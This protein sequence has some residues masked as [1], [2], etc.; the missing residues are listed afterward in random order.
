MLASDANLLLLVLVAASAVT[1]IAGGYANR[2]VVVYVFKPLTM[3][4]VLVLAVQTGEGVPPLYGGLVL[5]GLLFSLA[6]DVLL[7]LPSDRF[8]AGLASFLV[9]HLLY[10]AA[11]ASDGA[12]AG[13]L[14]VLLPYAALGALAYAWLRPGLGRLGL[15]VAGYVAAIAAMTGLATARWLGAPSA[16]SAL[17]CAGAV[18]FLVSDAVL[19]ANRFRVPFASA[20][21][22]IL[23]TYFTGQCLIA[24]STGVGE[25]LLGGA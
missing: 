1:C 24:L 10:V 7:M 15:P 19:A 3:L 14:V 21:A 23:G 5:A 9:A 13:P 22:L 12:A 11:F 17:A 6:G 2:L 8:L 20:Q 18:L 25:A 4:W 16:A